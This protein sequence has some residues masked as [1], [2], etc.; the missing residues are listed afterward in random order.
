MLRGDLYQPFVQD[1]DWGFEILTGEFQGVVIQI[2]NIKF[3]RENDPQIDVD[4]HVL[5]KPEIIEAEDIKG[6][7]FD[8]LFQTIV[9]DIVKEAIEIHK[10]ND[11]DD[12]QN[13]NDNP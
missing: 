1:K 13:R 7:L 5:Y 10:A 2:E 9:T 3:P 11:Q 6:P 12:K 4:Y 8:A